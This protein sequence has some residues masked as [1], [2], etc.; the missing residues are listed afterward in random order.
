MNWPF[1]D[2]SPDQLNRMAVAGRWD[3]VHRAASMAI[4]VRKRRRAAPLEAPT[5]P[6][7]DVPDV[8]PWT[9]EPEF[10]PGYA[11]PLPT[12]EEDLSPK[13]RHRRHLGD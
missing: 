5:L 9:D 4:D 2:L 11:E 3:L 13:L 10:D 12:R 7:V 8:S 1:S 6:D